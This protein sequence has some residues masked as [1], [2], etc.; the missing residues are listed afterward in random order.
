MLPNVVLVESGEA[1]SKVLNS[2]LN[3]NKLTS[4][5]EN[6]SLIFLTTN[7]KQDAINQLSRLNQKF[8]NIE[9]VRVD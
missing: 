8:D 1:T 5:Y 2:Y 3:D 6:R 7:N 4:N 9:E